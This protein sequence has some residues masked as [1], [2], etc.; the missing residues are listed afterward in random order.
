[1]GVA[2]LLLAY[3][4]LKDPRD[5][6]EVIHLAAGFSAEV[7]LIGKAIDARHWKVSR[8]L[9]SWRPAILE[10]PEG[11]ER[12]VTK[13]FEDVTAWASAA[14][15]RGFAIVA[16]V[17][18]GGAAPRSSLPGGRLAVLFGEET[19]GLADGALALCDDRWTLPLGEGGKFYTVGQATALILG[20][21]L[22]TTRPSV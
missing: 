22:G 10:G 12:V 2:D 9:R 21:L 3:E 6:A 19:A 16:T 14:R 17:V 7:Q 5:L 15:A 20:A 13:R 18:E 8:K 11:I 1:L 4:T